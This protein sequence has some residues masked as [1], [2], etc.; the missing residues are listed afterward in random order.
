VLIL[1]V[2][3]AAL[4]IWA[5]FFFFSYRRINETGTAGREGDLLFELQAAPWSDQHVE[6]LLAR[7]PNSPVL[8]NQYVSNAVDRQDWPEAE[9]RSAIFTARAPRSPHAVLAHIDVLRRTGREEEAVAALRRAVR[10]MPREFIILLAWAH[11][12]ARCQDWAEAARRL[13]RVRRHAP[14]R[15]A[16]YVEAVDVL[17]NDGRPDEAEAVI[18]EGM[19][20]LPEPWAM[21]QA[22]GLVAEHLGDYDEAVRRWEAMRVHFPGQPAGFLGGAEALARAGRGEEAAALIRQACDFFPGNKQVAEAAARLAPPGAEP[23][24]P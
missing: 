14:E 8:L 6:S 12:A 10:R 9:R 4:L 24:S 17:L 2:V 19:R 7:N 21:W 1:A 15:S 23:P 20:R 16:G 5:A 22:S 13:E 3:V 18:A 11:E